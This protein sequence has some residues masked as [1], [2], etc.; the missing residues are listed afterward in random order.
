MGKSQWN[1]LYKC[2]HPNNFCFYISV[3]SANISQTYLWQKITWNVTHAQ[4]LKFPTQWPTKI[5]SC[6]LYTALDICVELEAEPQVTT[7][8]CARSLLS[9]SGILTVN[10]YRSIT[11]I[12]AARY[13]V[14]GIS[15]G[16]I[17]CDPRRKAGLPGVDL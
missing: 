2:N 15:L 9:D 6:I 12:S 5:S 7:R 17:Q 13:V 11:F 8:A 4:A 1:N 10:L 16:Q 14:V 3:K